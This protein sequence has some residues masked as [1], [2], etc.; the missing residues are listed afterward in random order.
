MIIGDNEMVFCHRVL[1]LYELDLI[2]IVI[3][4]ANLSLLQGLSENA[5]LLLRKCGK[6]YV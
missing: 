6:C 1:C 4:Y 3:G 5:K 2:W